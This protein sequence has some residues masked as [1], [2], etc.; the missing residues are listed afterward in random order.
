MKDT[1]LERMIENNGGEKEDLIKKK[2]GRCESRGFFIDD[3]FG[4]RRWR[5]CRGAVDVM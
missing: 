5:A 2:R 1:M 3:E 4:C